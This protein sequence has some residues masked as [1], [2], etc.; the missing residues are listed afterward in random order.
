[1]SEKALK[2]SEKCKMFSV[3]HSNVL[4]SLTAHQRLHLADT[5]VPLSYG[6]E[7]APVT[8]IRTVLYCTVLYCT[9]LYCTV[10]YCTV[11]YCTVLYCTVLYCTVLLLASATYHISNAAKSS[12]CN[13]LSWLVPLAMA[14]APSYT[15]APSHE[16][17]FDKYWNVI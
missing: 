7:P 12:V 17:V 10:L 13:R 1:M 11:L 6:E 8:G 14:S 2:Y 3:Q 9:A 5:A 4:G 15:S 16:S